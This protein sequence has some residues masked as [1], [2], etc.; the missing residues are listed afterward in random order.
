MILAWAF[1]F[2]SSGSDLF[3]VVVGLS[4]DHVVGP[5]SASLEAVRWTLYLT[6]SWSRVQVLWKD[7]GPGNYLK[8]KEILTYQKTVGKPRQKAILGKSWGRRGSSQ[9]SLRLFVFFEK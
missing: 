4:E 8:N 5:T 7:W 1:A 9:K 2:K 3:H 6:N